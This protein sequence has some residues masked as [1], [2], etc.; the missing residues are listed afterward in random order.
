MNETIKEWN[1][2]RKVDYIRRLIRQALPH[3]TS[4]NMRIM[5]SHV[6]HNKYGRK[7]LPL[8]DD[9]IVVRDLFLRYGLSAGTVYGWFLITTMP[10]DIR[11]KVQRGMVTKGQAFKMHANRK[12]KRDIALGLSIMEEI[13]DI[14]RQE[15]QF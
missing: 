4:E 6:A 15:V 5:V 3:V 14:M 8:T 11:Y 2:F 13:R 10:E 12:W 9:E 7:A 1:Y